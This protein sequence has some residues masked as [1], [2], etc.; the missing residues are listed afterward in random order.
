[1]TLSITVLGTSGSY[2]APG[3]A[4]SGYLLRT[5]TTAVWLDCGSGSLA[6]LQKHVGLVDLDGIVCTHSHPDHWADLPLA[7]VALRYYLHEAESHVPLLWTAETAASYEAVAGH[8]PEPAMASQIIDERST[9][10]IGD[11]DLSFS[12]TDHPVE[13]LAVRADH[14]GRSIAYSSDTGPGWALSSLGPGLDVALVEATLDEDEPAPVH[15]TAG[16]AGAQAAAADVAALVLIH[17]AP[18]ADLDARRA[19]AA[20]KFDGPISI[21]RIDERY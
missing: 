2:P 4:C 13:T 12:R 10:R 15:L 8:P 17:L 19:A 1:M 14:G 20:E 3:T 21:A 11:I 16:Q 18:G 5:D 6:N 7:N 9:A